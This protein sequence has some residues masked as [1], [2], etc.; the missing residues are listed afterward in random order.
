VLLGLDPKVVT[1]TSFTGEKVEFGAENGKPLI[2]VGSA[3][4]TLICRGVQPDELRRALE[5]ADVRLRPPGVL[6]IRAADFR[7][8]EG[9][10]AMGAALGVKEPE[11]FGDVLVC[12]GRPSMAQVNHWYAEYTVEVPHEGRWT[13]WARVRYPTGGDHSFGIVLRA[14]EEVTLSGTQVLGNCGVNEKQWHWSGRG[15]GVTTVPPGQP[16]TFSLEKGPFTFRIYAREGGGSVA[17][18]PRLDLLCLTDDPLVV[19]TDEEAREALAR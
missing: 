12:T 9:E 16:I 19:P 13:L 11:A 17:T 8:L 18:N 4:N 5:G 6:F 14:D 7:K 3:R 10:M 2:P 15:G 1:L